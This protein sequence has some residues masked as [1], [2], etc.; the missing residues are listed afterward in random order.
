[1]RIRRKGIE[2]CAVGKV[3]AIG[4]VMVV[5]VVIARVE[6]H[7]VGVPKQSG[8]CIGRPHQVGIIVTSVTKVRGAGGILSTR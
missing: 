3:G 1:M 7:M 2:K 5:I 8:I 6:F 4:N